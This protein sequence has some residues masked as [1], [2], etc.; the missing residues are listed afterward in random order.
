[1]PLEWEMELQLQGEERE[2]LEKDRA[3]WLHLH[4]WPPAMAMRRGRR[5]EG[6]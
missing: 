4:R 1:M 5:E 3:E 6:L 2:G